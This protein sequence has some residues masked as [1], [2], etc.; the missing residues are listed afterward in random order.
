MSQ[1]GWAVNLMAK[2]VGFQRLTSRGSLILSQR[3][4]PLQKNLSLLTPLG[5]ERCTIGLPFRFR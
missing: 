4:K 1:D 2:S 3:Y 5:L